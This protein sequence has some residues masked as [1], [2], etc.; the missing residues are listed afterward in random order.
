[1]DESSKNAAVESQA[2]AAN[3]AGIHALDV[4]YSQMK[5]QLEK[6]QAV[7][8]ADATTRCAICREAVPSNGAASLVCTN[9]SC[10][11]VTHMQCLSKSWLKDGEDSLVPTH[12]TC[13]G[14]QS[15]LQWVDL[16]KDLSLRMRG[17]KE[18]TAVFKP[19]RSKKAAVGTAVAPDLDESEEDDD[20][21]D[22]VLQEEDDE[23]QKLEESSDDELD[24]AKVRNNSGNGSAVFNRP[25]AT[26]QYSDRVIEDS[27][28]DE[29]EVLT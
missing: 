28:W 2:A 12:G 3:T 29:A 7:F 24:I 23:W 16:V 10:S 25:S 27:D 5:S 22:M 6:S 1:M 13:P 21:M 17:E 19:K 26:T 4:G 14:C 11:A 8:E 9:K 20:P 15:E 18:I